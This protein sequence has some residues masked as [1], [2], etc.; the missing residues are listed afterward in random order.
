[1]GRQIYPSVRTEPTSATLAYLARCAHPI[2]RTSVVEHLVEHLVARVYLLVYL[3]EGLPDAPPLQ[4][5]E[6]LGNGPVEGA[7]GP[8]DRR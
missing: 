3:I 2:G 1:M 7:D 8:A 6:L 4:Q 5:P